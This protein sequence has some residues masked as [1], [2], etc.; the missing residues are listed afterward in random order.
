MNNNIMHR[1]VQVRKNT[2]NIC[3]LYVATFV[4]CVSFFRTTPKPRELHQSKNSPR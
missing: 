2:C 1:T 3:A 4:H